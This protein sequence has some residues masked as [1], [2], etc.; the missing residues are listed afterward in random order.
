MG[1]NRTQA[2]VLGFCLA[3]WLSLIAILLAAPEVF[4]GALRLQPGGSL[5]PELA[6]LVAITALIA[7]L[8]A[9][10]V[11]RWRW[12]FW[13]ILLAFLAGVI[14][15]PAS[16][17]ELTGKLPMSGPAWY[18]LLQAAIGVVQFAI[19]LAMVAGFRS[20]GVWGSFR[21]RRQPRRNG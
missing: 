16:A 17:L 4:A 19:G 20:A 7:L 1:L 21:L 6:F 15:V 9:G 10:V 12:M 11:R 8:G 3:A 18:V 5:A 2:L 13:L 14:R